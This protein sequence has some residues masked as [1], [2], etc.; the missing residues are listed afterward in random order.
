MSSLWWQVTSHNYDGIILWNVRCLAHDRK[1]I[2]APYRKPNTVQRDTC[3]EKVLKTA[4]ISMIRRHRNWDVLVA[5]PTSLFNAINH[6]LSINVVFPF[7]NEQPCM[8]CTTCW[9]VT[10]ILKIK[11]FTCGIY[12]VRVKTKRNSSSCINHCHLNAVSVTCAFRIFQWAIV[13]AIHLT[14]WPHSDGGGEVIIISSLHT[15]QK[16]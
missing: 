3:E 8:G 7:Y 2:W 6:A 5:R 9:K 12:G 16:A 13:C 11:L 4:E 10:Y 14:L 15:G 1:C